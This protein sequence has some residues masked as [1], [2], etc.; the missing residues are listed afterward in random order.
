MW[1]RFLGTNLV[2]GTSLAILTLTAPAHAEATFQRIP[3]QYIAALGPSSATSGTDAATWGLWPVDPGPRGVRVRNYEDLKAA[4]GIAPAGWQFDANAWWIEEN[5]LIMEAP[6]FPLPAGKY[7]VTG[8]REATAVLTVTAPDANGAQG[9]S[10]S[11]AATV[12]DVTHLRCRAALYTPRDGA[13]CTPDNTP[14]SRFPMPPSEA[15]PSIDGCSK[16]DYQ[17]L[18]VVGM[19][20]GD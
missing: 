3:T 5:G 7:V 1:K 10:L 6:N 18:I 14:L 20:V 19:M 9:W 12:Y 13:S 16:E 8:G 11:D 17:V 15:M 4:A 2:L